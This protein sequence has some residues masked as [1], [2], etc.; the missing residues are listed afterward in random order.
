MTG[1]RARQRRLSRRGE[2]GRREGTP[3]RRD[4][5]NRLG[6]APGDCW[7]RFAKRRFGSRQLPPSKGER[8]ERSKE[9]LRSRFSWAISS[10][11]SAFGR[12]WGVRESVSGEAKKWHDQGIRQISSGLQFYCNIYDIY[13]ICSSSLGC[14]KLCWIALCFRVEFS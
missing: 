11:E 9:S 12:L 3:R 10:D 7:G 4:C 1:P 13:W 6:R 2:A 5:G 14:N 8:K